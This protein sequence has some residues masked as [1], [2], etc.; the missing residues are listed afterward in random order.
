MKP[1]KKPGGWGLAW[2]TLQD[3]IHTPG[4]KPLL[5]AWLILTVLNPVAPWTSEAGGLA[6]MT[7]AMV[8]AQAGLVLALV[9]RSWKKGRLFTFAATTLLASWLAEWIGVHSGLPFGRYAYT[10][11]LQPQL[12][13]VPLLIPL[14]WL[15]ML[16]P[17]W[18]VASVWVKP[19]RRW[20][21]AAVSGL[22]FTAWDF[23]LDPQM[24]AHGFWVWKQPGLYFGI[25]LL[26][27]AGWW[28][29]STA[30]TRI[31]APDQLTGQALALIYSLTWIMELVGLGLFLGQ[32]LPAL[33]GFGLMGVFVLRYWSSVRWG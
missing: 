9:G 4:L 28:L 16:P 7:E 31:I 6:L 22:A 15:M 12:E 3:N 8:V 18:A 14:G 23:Y 29:V 20:L 19:Q 10:P 1:V 30:I 33:C 13:G 24:V 2:K 5:A 25:P 17:A 32:P 11:L 27:M 21:F 26:N